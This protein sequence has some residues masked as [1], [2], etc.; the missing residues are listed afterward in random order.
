[1]WIDAMLYASVAMF[2]FMQGYLG[3]EEAYKYAKPEFLFWAKFTVGSCAAVTAAL[4]AFRST[5]FGNYM[6]QKQEAAEAAKS[7]QAAPTTTNAPS[8]PPTP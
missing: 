4:K 1:M 8:T 3:T 5:T 7:Q 2:A 6:R